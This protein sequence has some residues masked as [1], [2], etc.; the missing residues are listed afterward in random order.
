MP[1]S[2]SPAEKSKKVTNPNQQWISKPINKAE[3]SQDPNLDIPA[4]EVSVKL[5]S[6]EKD[7]DCY[8]WVGLCKKG[9]L[10]P[11]SLLDVNN[12]QEIFNQAAKSGISD[13]GPIMISDSRTQMPRFIYLL[14]PPESESQP[15]ESIWISQLIKTINSWSPKHLGFYL[16]PDLISSE[17][18]HALLKNILKQMMVDATSQ[19]Y[20]LLQGS[21]NLNTMLNT[22]LSIRMDLQEK[23]VALS[24]FH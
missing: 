2:P 24:V 7:T 5:V 4:K 13:D 16:S 1:E 17:A 9:D 15:L 3:E 20:Y 23:N 14:P 21:H 12:I 19:E 6:S 10:H 8:F 18:S 11:H 22:A